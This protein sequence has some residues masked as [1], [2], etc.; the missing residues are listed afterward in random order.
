MDLYQALKNGTSEE[1]L[2]ETFNKDLALAR[3]RIKQE[4]EAEK[5]RA[6]ARKTLEDAINTYADA[7]NVAF[8]KESSIAELIKSFTE[9]LDVSKVLTKNTESDDAVIFKFIQNL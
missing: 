2:R 1:E 3:A 9:L 4:S 5:K 7:Y 6:A 8:D